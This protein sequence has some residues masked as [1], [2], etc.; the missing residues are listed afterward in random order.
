MAT[1]NPMENTY[2]RS[3]GSVSKKVF[4]IAGIITTVYGLEELPL[5][6]KEVACLW[7]LHPRLQTQECMEPIAVSTILD[8]NARVRDGSNQQAS[9][10]LIAVSFDQR[11]HGSREVD[12]LSN[13]AW[14]SGNPKHAQD[15]FSNYRRFLYRGNLVFQHV[16]MQQMVPPLTRLT[17]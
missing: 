13:E 16:K 9:Q 6:I 3:P 12:K 2:T 11:N 17:S 7:L 1:N 5:H 15:M 8:W 14:R 4:S 10:G